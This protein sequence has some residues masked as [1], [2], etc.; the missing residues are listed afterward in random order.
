MQ[1]FFF[2]IK[3]G[4]DHVLD[5]GAYDHILFLSALAIPFSFKDWKKVVIL[6]TVFTIA[7]CLSLALSA[8][9]VMT[10]DV[11]LIEFLIPVTILLTALYNF[12][13]VMNDKA[14]D[15]LYVN[16]I[17]TAFFGIIHGFGF[18]NYFKMLMAQEEDKVTPL[19]GFATGIELSQVTI[20]LVILALVFLVQ[21]VLKVKRTIFITIASI[22]VICITIPLLIA[23]FPN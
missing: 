10:V 16:S 20:I 2:Y 7:H 18:S 9:E 5:F 1:E 4:L 12:K 6:A 11:G 23:T 13:F 22:L 3:L 14:S 21:D 8:F 15:K 17:A 19:L